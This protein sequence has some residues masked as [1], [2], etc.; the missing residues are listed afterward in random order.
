MRSLR[1]PELGV[2][3]AEDGGETQTAAGEVT[4]IDFAFSPEVVETSV[5]QP[6]TWTNEDSATH[7]VTSDGDGPTASGDLASGET[8][9]VAFDA[10]GTFEYICTIHPTMR[11]TVEVS[12]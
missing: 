4:I 5:G 8:Y 3:E 11:G 2:G 6:V 10:A 7:T 9:E 12:A 1:P